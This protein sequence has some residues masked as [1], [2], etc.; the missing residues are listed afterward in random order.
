MSSYLMA[1]V[2]GGDPKDGDKTVW[3]KA[4]TYNTQSNLGGNSL[5]NSSN[6]LMNS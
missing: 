5:M 6:S 4:K 3:S 1:K 2:G